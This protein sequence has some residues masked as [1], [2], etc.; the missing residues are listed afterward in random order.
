MRYEPYTV[1]PLGTVDE[2]RPDDL[3]VLNMGPQHPATHGVLRLALKLDG[4]LVRE[5]EPVIGYLHRGFEKIAEGGRYPHF[6]VECNR[7]D[8]V[9]SFHYE[10]AYVLAV[11]EL[12]GIE[13]TP[14]AQ[15]IR[16]ICLELDRIQSHLV[17]LGTYG[18][19]LGALNAFWYTF[20][21]RELIL[22]L[23][24]ELT[25][26]RMH[27]NYFRFG[28]VKLELSPNFVEKTRAIC[29]EVE[30]KVDE[31]E[32]H[33]ATSDMFLMRT[34]AVGVLPLET[35]IDWGVT[36]PN[37]RASGLD[38]DLRREEPYFAYGELSFCVP[39]QGQGDCYARFLVRMAEM[40]ESVKMIRHALDRLPDGPILPKGLEKGNQFLI[41]PQGECYARI[42]GPRGEIGVY[43]VGDGSTH[44]YRV[45]LRSP[46]FQNLSVLPELFRDQ[47][48]ADLVSI[49]G[50]FDLVMGC[51]D[52]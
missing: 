19:D 38:F 31:Y 32:E 13:A 40:R 10:A 48:I 25:G 16:T 21:E 52:R 9:A 17:W 20:R 49:N 22:S 51:V 18:L 50:S 33:L 35:A 1:E 30:R 44:P 5:I 41:A 23:F 26:A 28:G 47:L 36:G 14:R 29:D 6:I 12:A 42:E 27:F 4:E 43:V 24:Q 34:Q 39:V 8:Y 46:C 37:A 2:Q 3:L 7:A 15:F 11:E 45:K